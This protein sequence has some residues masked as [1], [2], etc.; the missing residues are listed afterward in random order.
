MM[1]SFSNISIRNK[2][3]TAFGVVL[4]TALGLGGFAIERLATVNGSAAEVRDNWL[5][6]T[7]WLGVMAKAVEQYRGRQ[8][9][10]II[11]TTA[12]E[13]E[14]Q[15]ALLNETLQVFDKTWRLYEPT[16]TTPTEMAYVAAFKRG[17]SIY[18]DASKDLI[19][20]SRKN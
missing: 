18:L 4:I 15:E 3:I 10:H 5:P 17:W 19:E 9:Q 1:F 13:K 12:A 16:V 20:L 8:G 6:A 14:R 11:A 2:V 7:G